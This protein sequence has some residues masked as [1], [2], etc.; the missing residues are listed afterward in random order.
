MSTTYG[1]RTCLVCGTTFDAKYAAQLTCCTKC[2]WKRKNMQKS[3]E[4]KT[5]RTARGKKVRELRVREKP[6]KSIFSVEV[7]QAKVKR[8]ETENRDLREQLAIAGVQL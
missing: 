2:R 8:L 5:R 7:L 6:E 1:E 4:G 3:P